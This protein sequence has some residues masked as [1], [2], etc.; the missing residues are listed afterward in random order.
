[1]EPFS[2]EVFDLFQQKL[3]IGNRRGVH[4]NAV[5]SNSRYKFDLARLSAIFKS[6][7]ERFVLD[8]LTVK[9]L[10]FTFSLHDT[11]STAIDERDYTIVETSEA[12]RARK[13]TTEKDENKERAEFLEKLS[14]GVDNLIFQSEA[15]F[16]EKGVNAL[17]F[18]FPILARRDLTDGQITV[19]PILI[20][21]VRIRPTSQLNT[22][23][24]SRSEDDPIYINEVLINHLQNDSHVTIAPI[25]DQMLED[26]KIDKAELYQICTDLL[27]Q[28]K[29]KQNLDFLENNYA[30]ISPIKTKAAY[31][32]LLPEKGNALIE[33]AGLFSLFEVQKQNIIND[34]QSLKE[35]FSPRESTPKEDFQTFTSIPTDP[36]QQ[37]VLEQLRTQSHLLIQGPPGTQGCYK[38]V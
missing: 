2:K 11:P 7:P 15:I 12:V 6:L 9:N 36:S 27:S 35:Q 1:M 20:W 10:K 23:E 4:L 30:E 3:K 38:V 19:A 31:E 37:E 5:V 16:Q 28:L 25:P 8:L 22:W 14:D 13:Q 29:I 33:K 21:S 34:Y 26:G 17:G 18:G 32:A 24:I